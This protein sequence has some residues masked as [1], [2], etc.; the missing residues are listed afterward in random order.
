MIRC[1]KNLQTHHCTAKAKPSCD[2]RT[3]QSFVKPYNDCQNIP[4]DIQ[5][6]SATLFNSFQQSKSQKRGHLAKPL[7]SESVDN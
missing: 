3:V 1:G 5:D 2:W 4:V 6:L 7:A